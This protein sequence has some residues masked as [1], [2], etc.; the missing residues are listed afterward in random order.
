MIDHEHPLSVARQAKLLRISLRRVYYR[1]RDASGAD[2]ALMR[3]IDELQLEPPFMGARMLRR[4]LLHE[5]VRVGRRHPGTLG[6]R[7]G[8]RALFPKAGT[9]KRHP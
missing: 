3:R 2:L 5:G 8:I 1:P 7:L 4:T 6:R 9:S